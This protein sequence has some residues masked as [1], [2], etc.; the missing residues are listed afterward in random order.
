MYFLLYLNN[1]VTIGENWAKDIRDLVLLFFLQLHVMYSYLNFLK[2][3][4]IKELL[5]LCFLKAVYNYKQ[6]VIRNICE[7]EIH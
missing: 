5:W 3:Q 1:I 7:L 2:N 6:I 4:L